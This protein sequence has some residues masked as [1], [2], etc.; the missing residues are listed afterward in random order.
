MFIPFIKW[1][2][3]CYKKK[4]KKM[5][6]EINLQDLINTDHNRQTLETTIKSGSTTNDLDYDFDQYKQEFLNNYKHLFK[7]NVTCIKFYT[8]KGKVGIPFDIECKKEQLILNINYSDKTATISFN[9]KNNQFLFDKKEY[10]KKL[11]PVIVNKFLEMEDLVD[12]KKAEFE[13]V[14]KRG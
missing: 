3:K 10:S 2:L 1:V 7:D 4:T 9:F 11:L 13:F 14:E 8:L 12:T 6:K 5:K